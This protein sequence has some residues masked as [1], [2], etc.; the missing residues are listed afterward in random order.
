MSISSCPLSRY[1]ASKASRCRWSRTCFR[2]CILGKFFIDLSLE[3]QML[4]VIARG[5][6][7]LVEEPSQRLSTPLTTLKFMYLQSGAPFPPW[8]GEFLRSRKVFGSIAEVHWAG[9]RLL[10]YVRKEQDN[11]TARMPANFHPRSLQECCCNACPEC[12]VRASV[13]IPYAKAWTSDGFE[14]V[15]PRVLTSTWCRDGQHVL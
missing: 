7:S 9:T 14:D 15:R 1:L 8:R 12:L 2:L 5:T 6:L 3:L 4:V 10:D 11:W 13:L